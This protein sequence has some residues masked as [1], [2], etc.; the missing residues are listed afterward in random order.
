MRYEEAYQLPEA[1]CKTTYCGPKMR[2]DVEK[3]GVSG[4]AWWESE[5]NRRGWEEN[6]RV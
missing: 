2:C 4:A 3:F 1:L 6:R 5:R